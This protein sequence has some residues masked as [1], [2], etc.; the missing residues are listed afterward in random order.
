MDDY[1]DAFNKYIDFSF[2]EQKEKE[3]IDVTNKETSKDT[4]QPEQLKEEKENIVKDRIKYT[5][6]RNKTDHQGNE[7]NN[8]EDLNPFKFNYSEKDKDNLDA[9]REQLEAQKKLEETPEYQEA[10]AKRNA[11][12]SPE[13]ER[14][15]AGYLLLRGFITEDQA[16]EYLKKAIPKKDNE[17]PENLESIKRMLLEDPSKNEV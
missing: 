9:F 5:K 13:V 1:N 8:L 4:N 2:G 17:Q 15:F 10:L 16:R 11:C 3:K 12:F 6:T 7:K 14:L